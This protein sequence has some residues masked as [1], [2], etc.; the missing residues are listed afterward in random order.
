MHAKTSHPHYARKLIPSLDNK[1][2]APTSI[3]FLFNA[4]FEDALLQRTQ[5]D[6]LTGAV[7]SAT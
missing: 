6:G 1:L 2:A 7:C 4:R 3:R 5:P